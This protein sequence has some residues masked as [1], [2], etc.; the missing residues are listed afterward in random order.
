MNR[1]HAFLATLIL[2]AF[3]PLAQAHHDTGM[4]H[5]DTS[6][7]GTQTAPAQVK[8]TGCWIR[9]LPGK[10]PS[11]AYFNI[12]NQADKAIDL[13]AVQS[14]S[15]AHSMLHTTKMEEGMAKMQ[16]TPSVTIPAKGQLSFAPG[17]YHVMLEQAKG[18]IAVG[19]S[20]TLTLIFGHNQAL[21]V[22]CDVR[23]PAGK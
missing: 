11:A 3:A 10:L 9:V 23:G 5:H 17:G 20:Q 21:P 12:D 16:H 15:Y 6:A 14:E 19:S 1:V 2:A 18:D 7:T 4:A 13:Q 8:V 22:T